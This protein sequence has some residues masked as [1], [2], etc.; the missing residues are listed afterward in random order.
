MTKLHNEV[1]AA[2]QA[3]ARD[4]GDKA[5]LADASP[6]SWITSKSIYSQRRPRRTPPPSPDPTQLARLGE[7]EAPGARDELGAG[8][9]SVA[10][11]SQEMRSERDAPCRL[12]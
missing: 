5:K 2:N 4:F 9:G 1:L 6:R 7:R 3:Y 11:V 8:Q 12:R 10:V